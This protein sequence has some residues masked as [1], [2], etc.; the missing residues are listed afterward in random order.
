MLST[1]SALYGHLAETDRPPD[2]GALIFSERKIA[3]PTC[4]TDDGIVPKNSSHL[5]PLVV[6]GTLVGRR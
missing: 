1:L 2:A 3:I 4:E 5:A 6:Q